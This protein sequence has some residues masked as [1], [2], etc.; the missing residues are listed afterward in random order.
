MQS[1]KVKKICKHTKKE[2]GINFWDNKNKK[3]TQKQYIH[4]KIS[5]KNEN[6]EYTSAEEKIII[7]NDI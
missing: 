1:S 6:T 2:Q 3:S 7:K 5:Q 4:N